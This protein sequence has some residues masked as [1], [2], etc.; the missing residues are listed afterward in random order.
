MKNF[1]RFDL[2]MIIAFVIVALLGG[3]AWYWLSGQLTAAQTD[4]AAAASEFDQYT[5][6]EVYLPTGANV[7]TLQTE[8]DLM[9]AQLDPLVKNELQSPGNLLSAIQQTD[10]VAWKH[11]L[12][13]EMKGLNNEAK[14]SG[15]KVPDNFYYG[16]SRYLNTNP[17]QDATPVLSRQLLGV[18][19]IADILIKAPV[20]AIVSVKRTYEEDPEGNGGSRGYQN[21]PNQQNAS[22]LAG[23][24]QE[25]SGGVYTAYPFEVEF[26]AKTESFRKIVNDLMKSPYVFVIRSILV[27]NS[28]LDSPKDPATLDTMAGPAATTSPDTSIV[29]SSPGAVAAAQPTVGV[30]YLFGD[31]TL[32]IR[33]RIDLIEWHGVATPPKAA[34]RPGRGGAAGGGG[35]GGRPR[36]GPGGTER[37]D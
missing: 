19:T 9:T 23:R 37:G 10:T 1:S 11:Q 2:G 31:E 20:Q 32:H 30:Q 36:S 27:Q 7:K 5:K 3:G 22:Q 12:D 29:N 8:I 17:T 26:D 16:F 34:T 28:Q 35:A 18:K 13:D 24:S 14:I 15:I 33:M 4:V 21:T 25:A 6:K